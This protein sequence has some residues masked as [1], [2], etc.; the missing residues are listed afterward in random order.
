L[1]RV[2]ALMHIAKHPKPPST[3]A[4]LLNAGPRNAFV[5]RAICFYARCTK[6]T[7]GFT[8]QAQPVE[9]IPKRRVLNGRFI[10]AAGRHEQTPNRGCNL[11]NDI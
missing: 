7:M 2:S 4:Q 9:S 8:E 1:I 3:P 10:G 5:E 6:Y 11:T